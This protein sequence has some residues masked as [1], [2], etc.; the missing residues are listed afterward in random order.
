MR[1][2]SASDIFFPAEH[3]P[4]P[5][6]IEKVI[7]PLLPTPDSHGLET[8][9]PRGPW[10]WQCLIWS[11]R[12]GETGPTLFTP[13]VGEWYTHEGCK[14]E[15][16]QSRGWFATVKSSFRSTSGITC[17]ASSSSR[18]FLTALN[19]WSRAD[20]SGTSTSHVIG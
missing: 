19:T 16:S 17:I 12:F 5:H 13:G 9:S 11:H 4:R 3:P 2:C 1:G 10:R 7:M 20:R 6:L 18:T 15:N 14:L 8:S